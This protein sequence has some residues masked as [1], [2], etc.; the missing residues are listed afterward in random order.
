[1]SPASAAVRR[2]RPRSRPRTC[3][4]QAVATWDRSTA[5][6]T[7]PVHA[8]V[9]PQPLHLS[10]DVGHSV[11]EFELQRVRLRGAPRT[12]ICMSWSETGWSSTPPTAV[13]C[14]I[15]LPENA[16]LVPFKWSGEDS[17]GNQI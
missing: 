16:I 3:R 17:G 13:G 9:V 11:T 10:V 15:Y 12:E 7:Q 6:A 14:C 8:Q 5:E 2:V 1:M 4:S